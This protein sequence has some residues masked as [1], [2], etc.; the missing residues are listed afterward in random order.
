MSRPTLSNCTLRAERPLLLPLARRPSSHGRAEATGNVHALYRE[1]IVCRCNW[2]SAGSLGW[3]FRM[4]KYKCIS[5]VKYTEAI[6]S[7][8]IF[9]MDAP[10][11]QTANKQLTVFY[12]SVVSS[13]PRLL[14]PKSPHWPPHIGPVSRPWDLGLSQAVPIYTVSQ[15]KTRHQTL[16]HNFPKC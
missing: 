16:A 15:K 2:H 7:Q 11:S 1:R 8:H 4:R 5:E 10:V 14:Q 6:L 3:P 12:A 9:D 13:L